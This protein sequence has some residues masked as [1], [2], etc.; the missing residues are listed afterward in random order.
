[1]LFSDSGVRWRRQ[2]G[3]T[4]IELLIVVAII[5]ILAAIAVPNFLEAQTRSKVSR[6]KADMRTMATCLESYAVD[7]NKY[8]DVDASTL[9][10]PVKY[11]AEYCRRVFAVMSTPVA[12]LTNATLRDVFYTKPVIQDYGTF[13]G[14]ANCKEIAPALPALGITATDRQLGLFVEQRWLLQSVGPDGLPFALMN[15]ADQNFQLTFLAL[16][17]RSQLGYF[18]DPT[19]G[20]VSTGD[21]ARTA[22]GQL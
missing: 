12:Y 3:F 10:P 18:Y 16:S 4:L 15:T 1:M 11:G 17:D 19:N 2:P 20:T 5:A 9:M 13:L 14:Y 6:V 22:H 21:I 8:P 7:H